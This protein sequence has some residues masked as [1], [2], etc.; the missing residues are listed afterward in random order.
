MRIPGKTVNGEHAEVSC[1]FYHT[2]REDIALMAQMGIKAFRFSFSWPRIIP[3]GYGKVNEQGI[4]FYSDMINCLLEHGIE[5]YA[6]LYN[7]DLP[8]ELQTAHD[9]WLNPKTSGIER[10]L[11]S[12]SLHHHVCG[13]LERYY[14]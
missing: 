12:E 9:G 5:P 7:W 6:T 10:F 2:Y 11:W 3:L 13:Q 14:C 1:D 8:L 4:Q